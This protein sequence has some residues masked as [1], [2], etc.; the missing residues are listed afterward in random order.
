MTNGLL[1]YNGQM[2]SGKGDFISLSIV[3]G[4]VQF[5]FNLGSGIANI[6]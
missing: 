4:K 2:K 6:T 5:R 3:H 1:F